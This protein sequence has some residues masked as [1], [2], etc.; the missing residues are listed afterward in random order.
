M[1]AVRLCIMLLVAAALPLVVQ[2]EV[3]KWKDK[4]GTVRYSDTPPTSNIKTETVVKKKAVAAPATNAAA[5][6]KPAVQRPSVA[7][8]ETPDAAAERRREQA[9]IDKRNKQEKEAEAQRKAENC[10]A[11]KSN[12]E[13]YTQGGRIYNI[14]EKGERVYMDEQAF[15]QGRQKAQKEINENC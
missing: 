2:A 6:T 7:V 5:S 1:N 14:N 10:I 11:A 12:M 9:E 13:A 15:E 8:P 4:D 3:Y